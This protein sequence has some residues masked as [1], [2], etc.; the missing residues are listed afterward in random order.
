M[1][2]SQE[3]DVRGRSRPPEQIRLVEH[4]GLVDREHRFEMDPRKQ[5]EGLCPASRTDSIAPLRKHTQ[6]WTAGELEA[7]DD[8]RAHGVLVGDASHLR[9][10]FS[11]VF[12]LI[13]AF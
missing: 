12:G 7:V 8:R 10:S 13:W 6:N 3:Q 11:F 4:D 9:I 1:S 5:R 2:V